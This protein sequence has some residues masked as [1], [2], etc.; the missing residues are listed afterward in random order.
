MTREI[1][2]VKAL[3]PEALYLGI[4][5]GAVDN[6]SFLEQHTDKQL[7]DYFHAWEYLPHLAQA[8][9]PAKT[10][11]PQCEAWLVDKR[12]QLK[13]QAGFADELIE[14]AQHLSNKKTH[15]KMVKENLHKALNYF[16][17]QRQRMDYSSFHDAN[18]P[19]GSGVRKAA[20]KVLV[21]QR[22]CGSGMRWKEKGANLVLCLRAL[23]Q[24]TGRWSQFW[25]K[26]IQFGALPC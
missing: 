12:H 11:K 19:I 2:R 8:A 16:T 4:A 17:N 20:C 7:L 26:I 1:E 6:W 14:Q 5:D 9:Y 25:Q 24:S 13:H 22:L 21:K 18:L 23:S 15:G 3:Y 10:D